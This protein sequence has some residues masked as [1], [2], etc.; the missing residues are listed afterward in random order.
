ADDGGEANLTYTWA[1]TSQPAG[2][3]PT[4]SAN[5]TNVAKNS[6]VTFDLAGSY[7]FTVTISDGTNTVTS[8]V[9]V[10]V[11]QTATTIT[12]SPTSATLNENATQQF[13]ATAFD[14]FGNALSSQPTFTWSI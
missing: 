8:S 7:T 13:S 12:L 6:T 11:N 3:N 10:T 9:Q 2:S 14:Q 4:F 1:A 5:G